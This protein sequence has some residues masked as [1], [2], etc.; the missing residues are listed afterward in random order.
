MCDEPDLARRDRREVGAQVGGRREDHADDVVDAD[1]VALEEGLEQLGRA[2]PDVVA[3]VALDRRRATQGD[4]TWGRCGRCLHV[5]G[6]PVGSALRKPS[7]HALARPETVR[8]RAAG[9]GRELRRS[10]RLAGVPFPGE[11]VALLPG[12]VGDALVD[13]FAGASQGVDLVAVERRGGRRLLRPL[14]ESGP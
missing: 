13:L 2:R 12:F 1:V 7:I 6:L 8:R 4:E 5:G 11:L 9:A 14:S 3:G 10:R